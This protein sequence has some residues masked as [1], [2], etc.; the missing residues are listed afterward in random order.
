[1]EKMPFERDFNGIDTIQG[2][3]DN[4]RIIVM[5]SSLKKDSYEQIKKY[6]MG[7]HG[8]KEGN[9]KNE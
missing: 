5:H 3:D 2:W 9:I 6:L 1:V 8:F 4:A 7:M